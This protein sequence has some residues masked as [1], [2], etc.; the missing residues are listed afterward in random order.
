MNIALLI[1][2]VLMM[3]VFPL[4]YLKANRAEGPRAKRLY[5]MAL[6]TLVAASVAYLAL[7]FFP[8]H[9]LRVPWS[10]V[11]SIVIA[12]VVGAIS[13]GVG[14][15]AA[16]ELKRSSAGTLVRSGMY[17]RLRHPWAF[18]EISCFFMMAFLV[19]SGVLVA[20]SFVWIPIFVLVCRDEERFLIERFGDEYERYREKVPFMFPALR[21]RES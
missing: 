13:Y 19:H 10:H 2:I 12:V 6:L 20:L 5:D 11:V 4:V 17:A 18:N 7:F 16:R 21:R 8:F 3:I 15:P 1:V 9:W 14:I